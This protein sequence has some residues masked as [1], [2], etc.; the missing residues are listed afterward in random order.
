MARLDDSD[1]QYLSHFLRIK[2]DKFARNILLELSTASISYEDI[3]ADNMAHA[4]SLINSMEKIGL[5]NSAMENGSR[6]YT[7]TKE[8]I[9]FVEKHL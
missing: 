4:F 7:I 3:H 6:L 9:A 2:S 1:K 8:G 5:I